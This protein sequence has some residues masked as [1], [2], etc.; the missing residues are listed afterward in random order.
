MTIHNRVKCVDITINLL[1]SHFQISDCMILRSD[2]VGT[3]HR[4]IKAFYTGMSHMHVYPN[5]LDWIAH[6]K[7]HRPGKQ[8]NSTDLAEPVHKR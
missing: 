7:P 8:P 1:L 5:G 2:E 4:G 6:R 3:K